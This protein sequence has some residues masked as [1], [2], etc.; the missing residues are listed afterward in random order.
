[1]WFSR[2]QGFK[3]HSYYSNSSRNCLPER[4]ATYIYEHKDLT[5]EKTAV[6]THKTTFKIKSYLSQAPNTIGVE[7]TVKCFLTYKPLTNNAAKKNTYKNNE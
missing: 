7:L 4:V 3:R 1:V 5:P 2:G 6:L